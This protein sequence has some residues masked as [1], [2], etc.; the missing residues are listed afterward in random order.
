M[1]ALIYRSLT[2]GFS[3]RR[4][5]S[6]DPRPIREEVVGHRVVSILVVHDGLGH[7]C[8]EVLGLHELRLRVNLGLLDQIGIAEETGDE[9]LNELTDLGL[10]E[11]S[12]RR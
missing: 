5:D 12:R 11:K 8:L 3:D 4:D 6:M 9:A 10:L 2:K 1:D 7:G